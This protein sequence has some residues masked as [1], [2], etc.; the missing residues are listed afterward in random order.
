MLHKPKFIIPQSDARKISDNGGIANHSND[1]RYLILCSDA[2]DNEF[3]D[4][5]NSNNIGFK[6][7]KGKYKGQEETSFIINARHYNMIEPFVHNQEAILY[8]SSIGEG[9][10]K[11][12]ER[13]RVA[14]MYFS[15]GN[16][17]KE[18]G[19]LRAVTFA[20]VKDN[21]YSYDGIYYYMIFNKEGQ[22]VN[23]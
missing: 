15:N 6:K 12:G 7:L 10:V 23:V 11:Y 2:P 8:L 14:T 19:V 17:P 13:N 22:I 20:T 1:E 3:E 4:Y 5:C 21:D 16:E 9:Y 18:L